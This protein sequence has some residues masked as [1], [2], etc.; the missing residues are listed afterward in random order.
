MK[1]VDE[2][3][4]QLAE[5]F[6]RRTGTVVGQSGEL[7]ARFYAVAAQICALETQCDWTERQ[8]FPQTAAGER[9]DMHAALRG[10]E[11]R[12]AA[13]AQGVIRFLADKAAAT[14]LVIPE[15]T[16]CMTAGLERFETTQVK[17]LTAG[18]TQV[19]VPARAAV[20]GSRGNVGADTIFAMAVAP[21]GVNRCANPQAFIG[22]T[23]RE[24]DEELRVRV[25]ETFQ[26]LPNGA[27]SAFYE[28]GAMSFSEV[29]AAAVLPRNRG[30]GTVDV[31]IATAAGMPET[32]LISRVK[33]YYRARR[34]IA[35]DVGVLAPGAKSVSVT[36][37]ITPEAGR[38]FA[39]VKA[40]VDTAVRGWFNGTR[41]GKNVLRAELGD[42]I[43]RVEGVANYKLTTPSEDVAVTA[44]Q[45]PQLGTL[46][47]AQME[48][49]V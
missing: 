45:L 10:V 5:E 8:C 43:F 17:T 23:D 35:V 40:A 25:M 20:A 27:N 30:V 33:D 46:T 1:T 29:A 24:G 37:S 18:S 13:K 22:G 4:G 34:E 26:R 11:R 16:V 19:D 3:Y 28:Q 32:A 41:L 44:S 15:G 6:T 36:V 7:A 38:E 42:L 39:A 31:V 14:D 9:L 12:E 49:M 48:G 2:V 47:I 21:V